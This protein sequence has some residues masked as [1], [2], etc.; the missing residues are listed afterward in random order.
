V[1][2]ALY[3]VSGDGKEDGHAQEGKEVRRLKLLVDKVGDGDWRP[4]SG[5]VRLTLPLDGIDNTDHPSSNQ[6]HLVSPILPLLLLNL[7]ANRVAAS[8][9]TSP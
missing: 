5:G 2:E 6:S 7:H 1:Q 3:S 9:F 4:R 8:P